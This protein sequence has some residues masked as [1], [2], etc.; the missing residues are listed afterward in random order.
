MDICKQE[1]NDFQVLET[2]CQIA[3]GILNLC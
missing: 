3:K 1:K 2:C